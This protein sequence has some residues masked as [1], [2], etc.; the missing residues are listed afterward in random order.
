MKTQFSKTMC[1]VLLSIVFLCACKLKTKKPIDDKKFTLKSFSV[2]HA[3]STAENSVSEITSISSSN[4]KKYMFA[5]GYFIGSVTLPFEDGD[6]T[7]ESSDTTLLVMKYGT[8]LNSKNIP[9]P[10]LIDYKTI[11]HARGSSV[12]ITSTDRVVV[13]GNLYGPSTE[14]SRGISIKHQNNIDGLIISY[15]EELNFQ[16]FVTVNSENPVYLR[17]I[18]SNGYNIKA[19]GNASSSVLLQTSTGASEEINLTS[20]SNYGIVVNCQNSFYDPSLISF[21]MQAKDYLISICKGTNLEEFYFTGYVSKPELIRIGK[22]N[23]DGRGSILIGAIKNN[24]WVKGGHSL[25]NTTSHPYQVIC[26]DTN[27]FLSA[28]F[29]GSIIIEKTAGTSIYTRT[30][31]TNSVE[32][33][34]VKFEIDNNNSPFSYSKNYY[35]ISVASIHA[36]GENTI[37]NAKGTD[38]IKDEDVVVVCG[39][40]NREITVINPS[41]IAHDPALRRT[42]T[43]GG[44]SSWISVSNGYKIEKADKLDGRGNIIANSTSRQGLN[45]FVGGSFDDQL[46]IPGETEP[47]EVTSKSL[48]LAIMVYKQE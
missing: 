48:F 17:G 47:R 5:T 3:K 43:G 46:I 42:E 24:V 12:V 2:Y 14:T 15:D 32:G 44:L 31:P 6:R 11:D 16:H 1:F 38:I 23:L 35:P 21:E 40:F 22:R 26:N 28:R 20:G 27:L 18:A 41:G 45:I 4:D 33:I 13:C 9:E 34:F 30:T 10:Y 7:L 25:G 8:R 29:S 36:N 19:I 37:A 39:D